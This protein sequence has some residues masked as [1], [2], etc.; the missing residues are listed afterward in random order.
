M[1]KLKLIAIVLSV[2]F[3]AALIFRTQPTA[4]QTQTPTAQ[5]QVETAG[6]RFKN[7]KVLNDMPADQMG[8]V[9]NIMSASLGVDCKMC[10]AS[11]DK[12]FEKDGNEHK[13]I[14]RKMLTMTFELNKKFFDGKPEVSCNTCHSGKERPVSVPNLL[15]ATPVERPKQPAV[16]PLIDDI[17]A[18]Y[19]AS[20]G[21]KE[22]LAK[23]TSRQIKASRVEPDGKTVESEDV[24]Q[25]GGKFRSETKYGEYVVTEAFDGKDAWKKGGAEAIELKPYEIEQ[26]KRDAQL[27]ANA[28]LKTVY[29]KLDYR[30]MDRLDGREVYIVQATTADNLR[31]RLVFDVATGQLVR[32][33]ASAMTVLGQFQYQVDY[34]DWRDFGGVKLPASTRFAVPG[35]SWTRKITEVK[36]GGVDDAKFAK[37]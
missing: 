27:F 21:T 11:N 6:Q 16:K 22:A 25:K 8:Q 3:F 31:E 26:I 20:L 4:A 9:M 10:H 24:W 17:L 33:V 12:D 32:R 37:P 28:D 14:A 35:I 30:F 29:A 18:K 5:T 34:S 2:P 23:V 36:I 7:I 13:D 19:A 1:K 15:P